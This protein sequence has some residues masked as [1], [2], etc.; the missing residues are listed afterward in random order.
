MTIANN[1]ANENPYNFTIQGTG[2]ALSPEIDVRGKGVS[3]ADGD[4]TPST[5]DDTNFGS[6]S[7]ASGTVTRNFTIANTGSASLNLVSG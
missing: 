7:V 6:Q 4:T 5:T 3:I 2:T 1:D